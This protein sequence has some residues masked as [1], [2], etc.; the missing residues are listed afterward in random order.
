MTLALCARNL[1]RAAST[2]Q[3]AVCPYEAGLEAACVLG[4]K[5]RLGEGESDA[6]EARILNRVIRIDGQGLRFEAD[7]RHFENL[8]RSMKLVGCKTGC[9]PAVK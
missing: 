8:A 6:K 4:D 5:V 2:I 9:S 7:P 1:A 3:L